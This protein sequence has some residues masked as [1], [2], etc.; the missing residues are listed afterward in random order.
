[1]ESFD[2]IVIGAGPGGYVAA[3]RAAACGLRSALI[4]R[5]RV[6]GVC[7]NWGCIPTKTL[8]HAAHLYRGVQ[9]ARRFGVRAGDL[10]F[11]YAAIQR[12]SRQTADRLARGVERLLD[13]VGVVRISGIARLDGRA[14]EAFRVAVAPADETGDSGAAPRTLSAPRVILATGARARPLPKL[15]FDGK[16]IVSSREA[17]GWTSVPRRLLI[18]GGGVIGLEFADLFAS[19]GAEVTV[20]ELLPR[21]LATEEEEAANVLRAALSRRGVRFLTDTQVAEAVETDAG[22]SCRL[23]TGETLE[24]DRLLAAVGIVADLEGLGLDS[25]ELPRDG[26]VAVD[27][28]L[29]TA[30]PGLYAIGDLTGPPQLAHRASAQGIH[31][32]EA[33]AGQSPPA[34]DS[35]WTPAVVYTQPQL[36]SVGLQ[37]EEARARGIGLRVGRF[38]FSASGKAMTDGEMAGFVKVIVEQKTGRLIGGVIAGSEA[39]ELIGE[40]AI[41]GR[42]GLP[43]DE[44]IR[45]QHPHPTLSEAVGEALAAALGQPIHG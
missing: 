28:H 35:N 41:A 15:P 17:L 3:R 6:G 39:G 25:V 31:A 21:I 16:R 14:G 4:E 42:L 33:A 13:D 23:Q 19:F 37:E 44:L 30:V 18:A 5:E 24:V 20:I 36:A 43:V 22:L 45:V 10:S 34:Y 7:L 11:D 2:L 27:D 12:R 9:S 32:A 40:L 8:L 26:Y 1:M 29:R 38:A